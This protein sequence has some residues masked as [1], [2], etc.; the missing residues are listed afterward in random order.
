VFTGIFLIEMLLKF[1]AWGFQQYFA[2]Y[3]NQL[4]CFLVVSS[5]L[6]FLAEVIL[7]SGAIPLNPAVFRIVRV[8]R[9]TRALKSIRMVRRVKGVARLVDTLVIAIPAMANVASLCF[10]VIFIFAVMGM[11]FFG[12]DDIDGEDAG[13]VNGMYN[14]HSN[15]QNFG[16]AFMLLFRSVTGEAWNGVM[17][18]MMDAHC[19]MKM[20][21]DKDKYDENDN[22]YDEE[23]CGKNRHNTPW[24][25]FILFQ[26][27]VTG[28]LFELVTAIV[29]DEFSKMQE[30]EKLPVNTD[31]ISSFN[32]N[33]AIM[34]PKATQM[35]PQYHLAQF[36]VK[37]HEDTGDRI[38]A[39]AKEA[40]SSI[41]QMNVVV[42]RNEDGQNMVHYVDTLLAVVR[43]QYVKQ[44]KGE[45]GD[46][47][48]D[49]DVAMI[50]S[51][52][53]TSRIVTAYPHLT[54]IEE[55]EPKDFKKELAASRM[56]NVFQKNRAKAKVK[57]QKTALKIKVCQIRDLPYKPVSGKKGGKG[58][59]QYT[60]PESVE[61]M[62][63]SE[64]TA[65]IRNSG[66]QVEIV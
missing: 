38:F 27:F 31:M 2:D 64:M 25:F 53:L 61:S 11:D 32:D 34:D 7:T 57:K 28:L 33:W 29:L 20:Y 21:P 62:T 12:N 46:I 14:A 45:N 55:M 60:F 66:Q 6:G 10:L 36:M 41:G 51:P 48:V 59:S 13:Y 22:K 16:D 23:W 44:L 30:N 17:H 43:Y 37:L 50:E 9:L 4:D 56:Q 5:V 26:T 3:W 19:D 39:D 1:A 47:E 40:K 24:I 65:E 42:R 52:D 18:D 58:S 35:I 49:L 63:V 15:F 8:A 54:K